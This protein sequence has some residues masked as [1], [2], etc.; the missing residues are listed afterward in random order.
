MIKLI[1][2]AIGVVIYLVVKASQQSEKSQKRITPVQKNR[3]QQSKPVQSSQKSTPEY[4]KPERTFLKMPSDV[5]FSGYKLA[6]VARIDIILAMARLTD[7]KGGYKENGIMYE[8][9]T[10]E[11]VITI[12]LVVEKDNKKYAVFAFYSEPE[13][14]QFKKFR[15]VLLEKAGFTECYYVSA[16]DPEKYEKE[17]GHL[18]QG[19]TF[20]AIFR[21]EDNPKEEDFEGRYAMWWSTRK[22]GHFGSSP[23][24][25][26]YKKIYESIA[27]YESIFCGMLIAGLT[28]S[29]E[30]SRMNLP[31]EEKMLYVTGPENKK[32]IIAISQEKGMRFLLPVE[33]ENETYRE[34]ILKLI[35]KSISFLRK[36]LEERDLP[37]D[38]KMDSSPLDWYNYLYNSIDQAQV[39]ADSIGTVTIGNP[40]AAPSPVSDS[41]DLSR[42]VIRV[43]ILESISDEIRVE[44]KSVKLP[45]ESQPILIPYHE[46]IHL[47]LA[48]DNGH[49][50]S[51]INNKMLRESGLTEDEVLRKAKENIINEINDKIKVVG[52]PES[53]YIMITCGG[54]HE[55]SLITFDD[56]WTKMEDVFKSD[57]CICHP[58]R[59]I[60]MA[61][62]FYNTQ[63]MDGLRENIRKFYYSPEQPHKQTNKIYLR[64]NG[65]WKAVETVEPL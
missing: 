1:A 23:V 13:A 14:G 33:K 8:A 21:K 7:E 56:F 42:A 19:T 29:E 15:T 48:M 58:V 60:L 52:D 54:N 12:P 61:A 17:D 45:Q 39:I 30:L 22:D 32:C 28:R 40:P 62:N 3:T 38:E 47:G 31:V 49:S 41:I 44:G 4:E 18:E 46:D 2:L 16:Y 65:G 5:D 26:Y 34:N 27:G 25:H 57:I 53:S 64:K 59:D 20:H 55:S 50:Y 36:G 10:E 6:G 35:S 63:A 11:G 51:F 24:S 9:V 37:K 43:K